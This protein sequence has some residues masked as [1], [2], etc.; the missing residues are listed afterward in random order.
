MDQ[1]RV[2][3]GSS[4]G[5]QWTSVG[6]SLLKAASGAGPRAEAA[7]ITDVHGKELTPRTLGL[8][9]GVE[10]PKHADLR[11][12]KAELVHHHTHPFDSPPSQGDLLT[13][14]DNP[15]IKKAVVH[16]TT[17]TY[18]VEILQHDAVWR[19]GRDVFAEVATREIDAQLA[20][21]PKLGRQEHYRKVNT[22]A[23]NK[24]QDLGILKWRKL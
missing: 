4:K 3:A 5:G 2:P 11:N 15:G 24:L 8:D 20:G 7:V 14:A 6:Q 18:E 22:A 1:P 17:G 12:P 19:K 9:E 10:L 16:S 21:G 23:L 13:T